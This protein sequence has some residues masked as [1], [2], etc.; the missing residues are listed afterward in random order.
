MAYLGVRVLWLIPDS[1]SFL[2]EE[3]SALQSQTRDLS[4]LSFGG[5]AS[6]WDVPLHGVDA[7][8]ITVSRVA[9]R[10]R[11]F[12]GELVRQP[13]PLRY[14][15]LR[16]IRRLARHAEVI[17]NSVRELSPDL[18][19]SHFAVPE[20]TAGW[21]AACGRPVVLTLR[22]VDILTL[23]K[24]GYGFMLDPFYVRNLKRAV[25]KVAMVTVA[26]RQTYD[27]ALRI[28]TPEYKLRLVPNGVD[29]GR[30]S[31]QPELGVALRN[32]LGVDNRPL[33]FAAGNLVPGKGFDRLI[34]AFTAV[35][36]RH[37]DAMLLIAGEGP[38]RPLLETLVKTSNLSHHVLMPGRLSREDTAAA[39]SAAILFVHPSLSEGFGNV[40]LE[41]MASKCPVV[42]TRT[43]AAADIIK[44]GVNGR[45]V[46]VDD[47]PALKDAMDEMLTNESIRRERAENAYDEV[48]TRYSLEKRAKAFV[49]IYEEAIRLTK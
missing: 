29:L 41:A 27:A 14:A 45:V 48:G 6:D 42:A 13:F 44:D 9:V 30:F 38:E 18:I 7:D 15:N 37:G 24:S 49:S 35:R 20:G 2:K 40:I 36:S 19:H 16:K 32:K 8:V 34:S 4:V 31:P 33:V 26:S 47:I 3:V 43:G 10:L 46:P 12:A 5:T 22:G 21:Q 28:G 1:F 11:R 39:F 23:P 25:R 17:E